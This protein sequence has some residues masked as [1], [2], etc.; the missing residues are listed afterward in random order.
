MPNERISM[1]PESPASRPAL[2][3][4]EHLSKTSMS[5]SLPH[6]GVHD[7]VE[8]AFTIS[9]IRNRASSSNSQE[10][11]FARA[12]PISELRVAKAALGTSAR[13]VRRRPQSQ[14]C[15]FGPESFQDPLSSARN[16]TIPSRSQISLKSL[17]PHSAATLASSEF[18]AASSRATRSAAIF[19][20]RNSP[21]R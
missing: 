8:S 5:S 12:R 19:G 14:S 10:T 7:R 21:R 16:A 18:A 13:V 17:Q 11:I 9:G 3:H 1:S 6:S 15:R 4:R 20:L 2:T